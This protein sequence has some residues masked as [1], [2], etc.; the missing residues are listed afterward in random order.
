MEHLID[1]PAVIRA[2]LR[3]LKP[4]GVF[5]AGIPAE[6]GFIWGLS[7]RCTTG[8]SY[9]LRTGANYKYL[10]R[11]EH[12]NNAKE[13]ENVLKYYFNSVKIE[14]FLLPWRQVAFY[15]YI[16]ARDQKSTVF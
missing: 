16:E 2:A 13:I 1:L 6:G 14:R 4:N 9:R 11:Y 5:Q 7:W 12:V 8:I 3:L 15:E 10:M